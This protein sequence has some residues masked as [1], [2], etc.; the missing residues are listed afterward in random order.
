M[1]CHECGGT[2][3]TRKGTLRLPDD[4]VKLLVVPD[5]EYLECD[6]CGA[7]L[8]PWDTAKKIGDTRDRKI[9]ERLGSGWIR[10]KASIENRV[11]RKKMARTNLLV[12]TAS[13]RTW[14]PEALLEKI[15]VGREK[16]DIRFK[17]ANGKIVTRSI[18]FAIVHVDKYLTIDEV[19]FAEKG[20]LVLLGARTLEGLNVTVNPTRKKLVAAGPIPAA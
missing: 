11:D 7:Q 14:L 1:R 18:G 3:R 6:E 19:V 5:V 15:G 12:G 4:V 10:V 17:M 9:S 20:D 13:Q 2:Y 8:Y 16:K